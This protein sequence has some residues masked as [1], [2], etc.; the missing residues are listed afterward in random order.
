MAESLT[1]GSDA[2]DD[3]SKPLGD[4]APFEYGGDMPLGEDETLAGM[5]IKGGP[6]DTWVTNPSGSGQLRLY[7]ANGNA[8]MD[9]DFD[10]DHGFG[11]AHSHNWDGRDRDLGNPVSILPR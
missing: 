8:A 9:I 1:D 11:A 4:G 2:D 7:D 6:P 10:H 5:P 3:T